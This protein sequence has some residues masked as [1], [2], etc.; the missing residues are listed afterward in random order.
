[1]SRASQ[2]VGMYMLLPNESH[3]FPKIAEPGSHPRAGGPSYVG[4]DRQKVDCQ[5]PML[6]VV[7]GLGVAWPPLTL[8]DHRKAVKDSRNAITLTVH[9][10]Q[11][12]IQC[13][14]T[15]NLVRQK[16]EITPT[17]S[18]NDVLDAACR[19]VA[20]K[21]PDMSLGEH[22]Y[23]VMTWSDFTSPCA[24]TLAFSRFNE[25]LSLERG[26][27]GSASAFDEFDVLQMPLLIP[28][29]ATAGEGVL[30]ATEMRRP[31]WFEVGV[32]MLQREFSALYFPRFHTPDECAKQLAN[33]LG[34]AGNIPLSCDEQH[35][36]KVLLIAPRHAPSSFTVAALRRVRWPVHNATSPADIII[37]NS[38][39]IG[40]I[41]TVVIETQDTRTFRLDEIEVMYALDFERFVGVAPFNVEFFAATLLTANVL[42]PH[43]SSI[44]EVLHSLYATHGNA[45]SSFLPR[46]CESRLA[47]LRCLSPQIVLRNAPVVSTRDA[48]FASAVFSHV[49][50]SFLDEEEDNAKRMMATAAFYDP[51]Q[52]TSRTVLLV[53]TNIADK[54]DAPPRPLYVNSWQTWHAR[55]AFPVP[56]YTALQNGGGY[57]LDFEERLK[58]VVNEIAKERAQLFEAS[59]APWQLYDRHSSTKQANVS[60]ADLRHEVLYAAYEIERR[61]DKSASVEKGLNALMIRRP[62]DTCAKAD[63]GWV[64]DVYGMKYPAFNRA[65]TKEVIADVLLAHVVDQNREVLKV[66]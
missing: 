52:T 24:R 5:V 26:S 37:D 10:L 15:G 62:D 23:C 8:K 54:P 9:L 50:G 32:C 45:S 25:W 66:G 56:K 38:E 43:A 59:S 2:P 40:S 31:A 7:P 41:I 12:V 22:D 30:L 42:S 47:T 48:G 36:H 27:S 16:L 39:E 63:K 35:W 6:R 28:R 33:V 1:M 29:N 34:C 57:F 13:S 49:I 44:R 64:Y 4:L 18:T 14:E 46:L 17:A 19:V 21:S 3:L 11:G 53:S 51:V 20:F 60:V 65:I 58:E 55:L 61:P